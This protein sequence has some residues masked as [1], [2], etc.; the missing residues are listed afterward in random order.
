MKNLHNVT[1]EQY[2]RDV[3]EM[4]YSDIFSKYC[5]EITRI[6]NS[7]NKSLQKVLENYNAVTPIQRP[8]HGPQEC[9]LK[10]MPIIGTRYLILW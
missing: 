10:I 3:S 2:H 6:L 1:Y 4:P 8:R 5:I 7:Q 9:R